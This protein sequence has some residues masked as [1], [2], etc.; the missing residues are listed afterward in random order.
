MERVVVYVDGF[1]LYFGLM[2]AG[3]KKCRWLDIYALAKNIL[4]QLVTFRA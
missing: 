2:E 1:N 4:T 3:L